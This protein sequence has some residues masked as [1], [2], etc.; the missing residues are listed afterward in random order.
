MLN[1]RFSLNFWLFNLHL[2]TT[3]IMKPYTVCLTVTNPGK[4]LYSLFL[5][6]GADWLDVQTLTALTYPVTLQTKNQQVL[7]QVA[8]VQQRI[9]IRI[10]CQTLC[11]FS[12]QYTKY[13]RV[14]NQINHIALSSNV[15]FFKMNYIK[16]KL[17]NNLVNN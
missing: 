11:Y 7:R 14:T 12:L 10:N 3:L 13:C 17:P 8:D 1:Y 15:T 5:C 2:T 16:V 6:Q 4:L 9:Y